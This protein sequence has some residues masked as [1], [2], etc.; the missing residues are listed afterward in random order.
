MNTA[1]AQHFAAEW[2]TA[3]NDHDLERVLL[4]YADDFEMSS[5]FIVQ[6]AGE[7]SG[8][9]KGKTAVRAYWAKALQLIPDLHF[10][11]IATLA[12]VNS[13]TLHYLGANNRLASEVFHFG[14][15]GKVTRAFAHYAI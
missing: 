5:P 4:H 11:L 14:S 3:W 2:I 12:G 8:V 1:F 7:P 6:L 10:E 9:L 13:I 15:D